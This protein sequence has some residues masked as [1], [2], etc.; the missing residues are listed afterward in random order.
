MIYRFI[1]QILE[2]YSI[3]LEILRRDT[4]LYS[5]SL[6]QHKGVFHFEEDF[7]GNQNSQ[8]VAIKFNDFLSKAKDNHSSLVI[9]P[10]YSCPWDSIRYVLNDVQRHP[11]QGKL[12]VLGGESIAPANVQEFRNAYHG[13]NNIEVIFNDDIHNAPGGV[14]LDPCVYIFKVLNANNE[15]KT[16]VLLQF[17]IQH[18]GVWNNAL[19]QQKIIPGQHIYILRNAED[20]INLATVIC[21]DAMVFDGRRIYLNAPGQ[22]DIQPYIILSIQMNPQPGHIQFREFRRN[23]LGTSNKD[24]ISINWSSRGRS[25]NNVNFFNTY[26][27]SNISIITDHITNTTPLEESTINGNHKKGLYYVRIKPNRHCFYFTPDVEYFYLR[28]RKPTVGLGPSPANRRRG[29]EMQRIYEYDEQLEVF[30]EIDNTDDGY[31]SFIESIKIQSQSLQDNALNILD[32]ERLISLTTGEI[33]KGR[34]GI[35][36]YAVN[37]L[38]SFLIEDTETIKRFTV[39]FDEKGRD[40]RVNQIG[41]IEDLNV[42]VL[43]N[44]ELYPDIIA[45]FKNKCSEVM[46]LRMNGIKYNYN[47][48]TNDNQKATV[49]YI[50]L[51]SESEARIILNKLT[52]LFPEEELENKR[53]VVWY[54]PNMAAQSY[55][56]VAL[57]VPK[58]TSAGQTD[59]TSITRG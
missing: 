26:C 40:Y 17:K 58:Y 33:T 46:F 22:W 54:K 24:V 44:P 57:E 56:S 16:I 43:S 27:K 19:E 59:L 42:N 55:D 7:F 6:L 4:N 31:Q 53:I 18:M 21:S 20:S 35:Y 49:A 23:I 9:T 11:E 48:V 34:P 50:G 25:S 39:T 45:S 5:I 14:L 15:E 38:K 36:W 37:A 12:W 28:I 41:K 13:N 1:D 2:G 10:E 30:V 52:R 8:E 32:K 3:D 29:P 51:S 47:L